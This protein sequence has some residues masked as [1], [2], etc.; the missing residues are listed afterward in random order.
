L[1]EEKGRK[2]EH[3]K[4]KVLASSRGNNRDTHRIMGSEEGKEKLQLL[5]LLL[6]LLAEEEEEGG[7]R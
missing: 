2:L 1:S 6:L 7:K 3:A 5:L 4:S